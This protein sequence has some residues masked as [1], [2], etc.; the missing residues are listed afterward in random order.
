MPEAAA[1]FGGL[2]YHDD[3][4]DDEVDA[5]ESF[6]ELLLPGTATDPSSE[7][8]AA[9]DGP[10]QSWKRSSSDS[11]IDLAGSNYFF[12]DENLFNDN[13][14]NKATAAAEEETAATLPMEDII[15][16]TSN[17]SAL[18]TL[19]SLKKSDGACPTHMAAC[20]HLCF[21]LSVCLSVTYD[22]SPCDHLHADSMGHRDAVLS[23]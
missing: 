15:K 1:A 6:N 8:K 12:F 14:E 13:A 3:T 21:L 4:S 19:C 11:R 2:V 10:S 16:G 23:S 17:H 9:R 18:H 7:K 22:S 5:D 20:V